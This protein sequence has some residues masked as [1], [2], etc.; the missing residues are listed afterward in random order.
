M[1]EMDHTSR[2]LA[3]RFLRNL[4]ALRNSDVPDAGALF[5]EIP[6]ISAACLSV[7]ARTI[8]EEKYPGAAQNIILPVQAG[9]TREQQ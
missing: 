1:N 5:P 9:G 7:K 4:D 8:H 3:D 2:R 6:P